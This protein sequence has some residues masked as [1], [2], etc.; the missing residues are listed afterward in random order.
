MRFFDGT[1]H[2]PATTVIA[3]GFQGAMLYAGT[4]ASLTGKDFTGAQ[5]A[6]YK[7]HGLY[8]ILCFESTASDFAGGAA[9]GAAHARALWADC[10]AKGVDVR[11]PVCST[12]DMHVAIASLRTAVAYQRAFRDTLRSLGWLGPIGIYG[13]PECLIACHDAEVAD[14]YWGAGTRSS[15][16]SYTNVWQDNTQ[17]IMVGGSPDDIDWVLI[18]LPSQPNPPAPAPLAP[19]HRGGNMLGIGSPKKFGTQVLVGPFG[20][21][22]LT[23]NEAGQ[24]ADLFPRFALDDATFEE[25]EA[26]AAALEALPR[27]VADLSSKVD[28]LTTAIA[29][30][31]DQV[32]KLQ[33]APVTV[34]GNFPFTVSGTGDFVVGSPTPG[35]T[36]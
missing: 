4:P 36:A 8:T 26:Q 16:P 3:D 2:P 1:N 11:D 15:Q 19:T 24:S 35:G 7:A 25:L 28:A 17:T 13:F 23:A 9:A 10:A 32:A 5:Y 31:A 6:D 34:Q 29:A 14:W 20:L 18:E 33:P 21:R 30:L 12:V 27:N 22:P